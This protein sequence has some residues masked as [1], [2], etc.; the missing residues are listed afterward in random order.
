[1]NS[2]FEFLARLRGKPER[3]RQMVALGISFGLTGAIFLIWI[4]AFFTSIGSTAVIVT[5]DDIQ[6]EK[7]IVSESP[8]P[9]ESLKE[10]VAQVSASFKEL[11]SL[12]QGSSS[13]DLNN[14]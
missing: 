10:S 4:S 2:M 7:N 13:A 11:K 8:S 9:F 3:E 6:S 12:F 5:K 14:Q 1:M